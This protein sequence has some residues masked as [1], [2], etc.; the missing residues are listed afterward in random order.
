MKSRVGI[1]DYGVG[2]WT[3]VLNMID[4]MGCDS[5]PCS[6]PLDLGEATHLVLPGV[7]NFGR[8]SEALEGGKWVDAVI[9]FAASGRPVL[10]ICLGM[11][12]LGLGSEEAK[13]V[14]LGL[15]SFRSKKLDING[16]IRTPHMGWSSI[17]PSTDHPIFDG[18]DSDFRFYFVHSYAVPENAPESIGLTKHNQKF[19][20]MVAKDNI[21]GVQFHPEK[22]RKYGMKLLENFSRM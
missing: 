1:L 14:G 10:G 6:S 9:S 15:M 13:G 22:S 18:W 3:S 11:Q 7:G 12:L 5:L 17:E 21:I 20:S 2:T 8:A 19:S 16:T 4:S